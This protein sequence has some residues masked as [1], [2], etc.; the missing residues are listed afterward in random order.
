MHST[1]GIYESNQFCI[2][3]RYTDQVNVWQFVMNAE[4]SLRQGSNAFQTSGF[5]GYILI[6]YKNLDIIVN[7]LK[8]ISR[9][10]WNLPRNTLA[11]PVPAE[12]CQYDLGLLRSILFLRRS[13]GLAKIPI[14]AN[15]YHLLVYSL[16]PMSR[17][18]VQRPL[19]LP[20][21]GL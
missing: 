18:V 21:A 8:L 14:P 10:I 12:L 5:C 2:L 3:N 20:V 17:N 1:C 9:W 4:A 16:P 13:D 19:D 7:K 11:A 6:Q 15:Q